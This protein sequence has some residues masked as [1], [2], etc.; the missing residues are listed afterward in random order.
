MFATCVLAALVD[1]ARRL[2]I[3]LTVKPSTSRSRTAFSLRVKRGPL[4]PVVTRP[5]GGL[6]L[7]RT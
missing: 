4:P 5:D 2:A 3:S 1:M 7:Y 6:P